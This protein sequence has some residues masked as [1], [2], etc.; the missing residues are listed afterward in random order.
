MHGGRVL[1]FGVVLL[2]VACSEQ[3]DLDETRRRGDRIVSALESYRTT[4][5]EYPTTLEE[6]T[7]DYLPEIPTPTWG[8][9]TWVYEHLTDGFG[10]AV[11]ESRRTGDGNAHWYAWLGPEHGW[12]FG[13]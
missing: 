7:P 12:Q 10:L 4:E 11:H 6:L 5:G 3:A 13:D 1:I 2:A 9:R 8:L